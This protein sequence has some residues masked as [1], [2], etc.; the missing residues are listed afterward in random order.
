MT[1]A[2]AS[3]LLMALG[4]HSRG[5]LVGMAAMLLVFWWRNKNKAMWASLIVIGGGAA[6]SMMPAHWWER[7][8]TIQTYQE[9]DSA[10]GRLNA[11]DLAFRV[12]ND[13]ITGGGF[14]MWFSEVFRMY[15]P[16]P[17]RHHAAHSI[18]FQ[19]LGEQGWIGL[20]LFLAIGVATWM[21]CA[22]MRKLGSTDPELRWAHDLGSMV[23][24]SMAGFAA[25]GAFL[26]LT[27]F[28]LPYN[29]MIMAT[30]GLRLA[31]AQAESRAANQ[32]AMAA[33]IDRSGT[34]RPGARPAHLPMGRQTAVTP[35]RH[36]RSP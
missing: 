7:M 20:G 8:N 36:G 34:R 18:Y 33:A 11:W 15:S 23:Q 30:I 14:M 16:N 31:L 22:K 13:R 4:T 32:A 26:S 35:T 3:S 9:D 6:L 10:L 12:A 27:W 25:A 1:G 28:D 24:V 2:M 21:A 29:Q 17:E 5:A 19:A